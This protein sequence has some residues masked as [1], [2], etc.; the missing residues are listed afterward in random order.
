MKSEY[1]FSKAK[2]GAVVPAEG[3]E[4]ITIRLDKDV[5]ERFREIADK[6]GR[7]GYQ[8][9]I[10]RVLRQYLAELETKDAQKRLLDDEVGSKRA[11]AIAVKQVLDKAIADQWELENSPLK[12]FLSNELITPDPL[13]FDAFASTALWELA[14]GVVKSSTGKAFSDFLLSS[15]SV[16]K[17]FS[18]KVFEAKEMQEI[19]RAHASRTEVEQLSLRGFI[20][21]LIEVYTRRA[22]GRI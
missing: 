13:I 12:T 14:L 15:V 22:H 19:Y 17:I 2:K 4:R 7:G 3:K 11:Y 20:N 16:A 6:E 10:N 8:T 18:P 1:D 21:L 9:L 5:L